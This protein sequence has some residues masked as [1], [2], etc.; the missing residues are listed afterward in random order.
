MNESRDGK[1]KGRKG[2]KKKKIWKKRKIE[3][4]QK[5]E[6]KLSITFVVCTYIQNLPIFVG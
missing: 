5:Q 6:E 1:K 4:E 3:K 2:G